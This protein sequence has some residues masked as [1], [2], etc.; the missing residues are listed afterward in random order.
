MHLEQAFMDN[1]IMYFT[2]FWVASLMLYQL[3]LGFKIMNH[4]A[5]P[6]GS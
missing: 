2:A 1:R 6:L 5:L 4:I 3:W